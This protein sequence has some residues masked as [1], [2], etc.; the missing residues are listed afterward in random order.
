MMQIRGAVVDHSTL[1]RWVQRFEKLISGRVR[2]CKKLVEG[3]RRKDE[4]YI[5]LKGK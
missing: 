1:Q 4:A 2:Q 3:S 5:K